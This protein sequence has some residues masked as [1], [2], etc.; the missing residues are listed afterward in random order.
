M[1]IN[2]IY[3]FSF[4]YFKYVKSIII[5][6]FEIMMKMKRF[7]YQIHFIVILL[8]ILFHDVDF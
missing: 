4:V 2:V 3:W 5:I 6:D 8:V 1:K 7:I